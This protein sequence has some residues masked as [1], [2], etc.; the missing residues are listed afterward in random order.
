MSHVN[1]DIRRCLSHNTGTPALIFKGRL[2]AVIHDEEVMTHTDMNNKRC[3][4]YM[5]GKFTSTRWFDSKPIDSAVET[6][7][8]GL[9]FLNV[10]LFLGTHPK[11]SET[12]RLMKR[13]PFE[14][15]MR[16]HQLEFGTWDANSDQTCQTV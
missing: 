7:S 8:Y 13:L 2:I 5:I 14:H 9:L 3:L 1:I 16:Q 12:K 10:L 15:N 4:I 11:S 6:V